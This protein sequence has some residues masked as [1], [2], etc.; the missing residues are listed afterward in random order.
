MPP[1]KRGPK[2]PDNVD[3]EALLEQQDIEHAQKGNVEVLD[4]VSGY[5]KRLKTAAD[6]TGH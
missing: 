5:S 4:I 1:K 3:I 2:K 6:D